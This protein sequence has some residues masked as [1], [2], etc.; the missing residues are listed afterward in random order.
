MHN[1]CELQTLH[2]EIEDWEDHEDSQFTRPKAK[3]G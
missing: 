1:E 3:R 2:W